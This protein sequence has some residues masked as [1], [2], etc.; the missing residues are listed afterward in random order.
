MLNKTLTVALAGALLLQTCCASR[1]Y[2]LV[3]STGTVLG[4]ELSQN[5]A[6][7]SPQARLG[8]NRAEL[9]LVP[10][11]RSPCKE[12]NDGYDCAD[13][14]GSNSGAGD[15]AEVLMELRY[16]G[17]SFTGSGGI[18]Q[19]LAIGKEAVRQ[20]GAAFM[21]ARAGDGSMDAQTAISVGNS[22]QT[23][24]TVDPEVSASLAPLRKAYTALYDDKRTVFDAAAQSLNGYDSFG[25]LLAGI[26]ESPSPEQI[27]Q[28]RKKL[29]EDA[30]IK[31]AIEA[32]E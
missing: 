20:P 13:V 31:A 21:F 10:T 5:H 2:C 14:P 3:T 22:L 29:E 7:Q 28:L 11:N 32:R 25:R 12:S 27:K 30:D 4:L 8:Y 24:T 26:P 18:Y 15:T 23:I 6:T 19:R 9:A 16:G 17:F 1:D